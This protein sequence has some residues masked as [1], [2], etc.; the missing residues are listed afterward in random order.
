MGVFNEIVIVGKAKAERE[1]IL[2]QAFQILHEIDEK[3][4]PRRDDS[5][6]ARI[7]R[8]GFE[9]PQEVSGETFEVIQESVKF[10]EKSEGAF[11]I[12]A[13]PLMKLWGFDGGN[14]HVP[15]SE[16]IQGVLPRVGSSQLI[17][18]VKKRKVG[19]RIPEIG[20]DLGGI[21]KGYACDR[22]AQ[23]LQR[24][25]I[26]NALVNVGGTIRAYGHSPDRRPWRVG[27]RH[28]RDPTRTFKVVTLVNEALATSGDYEVFF[29]VKGQRY[30]NILD[31]RTGYPP[32][33][34]VAVSVIAP[35]A[36]LADA[37]SRSFFVLGPEKA[38][39]LANQFRE[40]RWYL[41]YL[42]NGDHF[43]TLSSEPAF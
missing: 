41:I 1:R 38:P 37:L 27:I 6:I 8:K 32:A 40:I 24:E 18:D 16:E 30:S 20:I 33:K 15:A 11:D 12:T 3:M 39:F 2:N 25:G 29:V 4:N 14:P 31:P 19:F 35:S 5:E 42:A 28:P 10:F 43:K 9:K 22:V 7:N 21:L 26:E 17:L 36:L 13:L 23:F 34:T